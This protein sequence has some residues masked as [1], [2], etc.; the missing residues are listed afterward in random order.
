M[1]NLPNAA[2]GSAVAEPPVVIEPRMTNAIVLLLFVALARVAQRTGFATWGAL[3]L[4]AISVGQVVYA[5]LEPP[6]SGTL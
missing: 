4:A 1:P 6:I 5:F 2:G 3:A